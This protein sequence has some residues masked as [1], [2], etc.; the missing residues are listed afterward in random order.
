[1]CV[2]ETTPRFERCQRQPARERR[3]TEPETRVIVLSVGTCLLVPELVLNSAS[4]QKSDPID[5]DASG[6]EC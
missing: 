4:Q 2:V 1:M 6:R 5:F 3:L